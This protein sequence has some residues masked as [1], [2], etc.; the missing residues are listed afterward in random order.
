LLL[1]ASLL[2]GAVPASAHPDDVYEFTGSGWGH[3]IGLSQYGAYGQ[4]LEGRSAE[5]IL[6]HYYAGVSIETVD[7]LVSSG[8]IPGSHPLVGLSTPLWVGILQNATSATFAPVNGDI[9]FCQSIDGAGVCATV[10]PGEAAAWEFR[11]TTVEGQD[12]CVFVAEGAPD[13]TALLGPGD[14]RASLIWN[15][16]G[17]ADR[18][19]VN[20]AVCGGSSGF[21]RNCFNRG[22]LRIRDDGVQ[23]GFHAALEIGLEEYLY[24]LGEMPSSW[25]TEALQAQAIAARAYAVYRFLGNERPDLRTANDAGLTDSRKANCW[26]HIYSTVLDQ[27]YVAYAKE[28]GESASRWVAAVDATEGRVLTHPTATSVQSSVVIAFYHSSSGGVTETNTDVWGTASQPY[29]RSVDDHWSNSSAVANPFAEWSITATAAELAALVGWDAVTDVEVVRG[30][31]GA[32]FAFEGRSGGVAASATVSAAT[33]YPALGTRSPHIDGVSVDL[34]YPFADIE[35]GAHTN[36]ILSIW[37]AGITNG[38]GGEFYCPEDTLTRAQMAT[39][40]ARALDLA[41]VADNRFI[42][43]EPTSVHA[44]NIGAIA[45]AGISLGCDAAGALFCP[46]EEVSRAQMASFMARALN[47]GPLANGP[48]LDLEGAAGHQRNINALWQAGVTNG[49]APDL[50]C[51]GEPVTRA[52]MA[53]FLA[54]GFLDL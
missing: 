30:A 45:D 16:A 17:L 12:V 18:V 9:R 42:D 33:L 7:A 39:F 14:C 40:L 54:R 3:S 26:C 8:R 47:L 15:E 23:A 35:G 29:L 10:G 31:P 21:G 43:V 38:C 22:T 19:G 44:P 41:P 50:Y 46:E 48:F 51:P 52:Q 49:C 28:A 37:E 4:A 27:S 25:H 24:G 13:D 1:A 36:A 11:Q 6:E 20:G 32:A 5:Q 2:I 34:F 53:T